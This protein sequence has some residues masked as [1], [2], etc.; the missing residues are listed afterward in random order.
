MRWRLHFNWPTRYGR[1]RWARAGQKPRYARRSPTAPIADPAHRPSV[2]RLRYLG[3]GERVAA[4]IRHLGG[5]DLILTGLTALDGETGHVGPQVAERLGLPQATGCEELS[6][7]NGRLLARRIIEGGYEL[8]SLPLP[9]IA[10][11]AETGFLPRYPTFPGRQR[12]TKAEITVLGAA[13]L[14]LDATTVGLSASPTKVSHMELVPMPKTDCRFVDDEFTYDELVTELRSLASP[15]PVS[16]SAPEVDAEPT[17]GDAAS[18]EPKVWVVGEIQDG[19]LA[20]VTAELLSQAVSLASH[21][22]GGVAALLIG[23]DLDRAAEE[24][25]RFGADLVLMAEDDRL[26]SY[27]GLPEARIV[28]AAA[29]DR[30]PEVILL[31]ATTTGRDLAP[32]VAAMLN[33]GIAADCTDLYIADWQQR[34]ITYPSL[35][36]QVRPAMAGGVLATCLCPEHR[37]Q[38]A[39]VRPGVFPVTDHQRALRKQP[40]TL[41]FE[42]GDFAVEV[43]ERSLQRTDVGLRDAEVIV[44]GGAG[45]NAS[46]WH[47]IDEL[48]THLGVESQPPEPPSRRDWHHAPSK[49]D[50]QE[51]RCVPSSMSHVVSRAPSSMSSECERP[52]RFWRS[53]ATQTPPSS[54]SPNTESSM[55]SAWHCPDSY[56]RWPGSLS[57]KLR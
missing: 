42:P 41:Q 37:P 56:R 11:V 5:A 55:T 9:A 3:N 48:A 50:K 6:I 18:G 14:G 24:A 21:L 47:L 57:S 43:L 35:L 4:A 54:A 12:A 26:T 45:C 39:T 51:R 25:A 38:I 46:N 7:E 20:Q 32:R 30:H 15:A 44:A 10:T 49:W 19:L 28:A 53:I 34:G 31:G 27:R 40:L 17:K 36:H 33:T 2:R 52:E 13:D 23:S 1:S 8:L 16:E 22:G 29:A